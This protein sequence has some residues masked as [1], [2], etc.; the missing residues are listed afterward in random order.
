M[1]NV[2]GRLAGSDGLCLELTEVRGPRLPLFDGEKMWALECH[3]APFHVQPFEKIYDDRLHLRGGQRL[4]PAVLD[5]QVRAVGEAPV[6]VRA[7]RATATFALRAPR[8]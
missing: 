3:R 2:A 7:Q 4:V 6:L 1:R 8:R 5:D